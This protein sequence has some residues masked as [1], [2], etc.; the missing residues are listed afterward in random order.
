MQIRLGL[1]DIARLSALLLP[2]FSVPWK[3]QGGNSPR[4]QR[5]GAQ[6]SNERSL[7]S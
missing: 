2:P 5:C 6:L 1:D 7:V 4:G 3:R